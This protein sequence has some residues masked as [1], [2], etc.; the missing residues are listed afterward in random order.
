LSESTTMLPAKSL[1]VLK[2]SS[3]P[4][5]RT[6][7]MSALAMPCP[8]AS[9]RVNVPLT[10]QCDCLSPS[11][12]L[13][14]RAFHGFAR[15]GDLPNNQNQCSTLSLIKRQQAPLHRSQIQ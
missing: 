11:G 8:R 9:G 13:P 5:L 2:A 10:R 1:P 15:G 6:F 3:F 7:S 14:S 4:N 12:R